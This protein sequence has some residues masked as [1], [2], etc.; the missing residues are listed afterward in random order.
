MV[1]H[2]DKNITH[3]AVKRSGCHEIHINTYYRAVYDLHGFVKAS[4]DKMTGK[5]LFKFV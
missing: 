5:F 1:M 2:E 4:Y 3:F